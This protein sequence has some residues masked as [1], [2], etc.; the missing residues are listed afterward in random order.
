MVARAVESSQLEGNWA[1]AMR[2]MSVWPSTCRAQSI[3]GGMRALQFD[4]GGSELIDGGEALDV[5]VAWPGGEQ[6]LGFEHEAVADDADVLAVTQQ[7]AQAAEKV[8]AVA[9]Q[10]LDLLGEDD[11][12]PRAEIG[13]ARL[14]VL[15]LGLPA[16]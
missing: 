15:V 12:E 11:V 1:L 2:R 16:A 10:F 3:S 9:L 5:M 4:D 8:G 7:L 6:H 13:D 14:A